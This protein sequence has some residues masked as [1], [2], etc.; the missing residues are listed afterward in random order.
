MG[1]NVISKNVTY[2]QSDTSPLYIYHHHRHVMQ[3]S[4]HQMLQP[5][6]STGVENASFE[7]VQLSILETVGNFWNFFEKVFLI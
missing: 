7:R 2:I 4:F 3:S 6:E 5:K 1:E